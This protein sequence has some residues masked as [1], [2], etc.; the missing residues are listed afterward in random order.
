M[1]C[2]RHAFKDTGDKRV[3]NMKRF[4]WVVLAAAA[5]STASPVLAQSYVSDAEPFISAVKSRDGDKA[6]QLAND[7]PTVLNTRNAKGETALNI[8]I[9][10]SDE[11]WTQFLL[12]KGADPNFAASNGDTPLITAARVGFLPA[13][14]LLFQLGVKVDTANKMGETPLIVAVQQRE[15]EAVKLLL[16]HGADPDRKDSAAGYS[17]RDYAKRDNRTRD[18][19][20]AIEAAKKPASKPKSDDLNSFKL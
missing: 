6:T 17:A 12:G 10:R 8:V 2:Y 14:D 1:L 13:M 4:G 16:A 3:R 15:L 5:V 18:I 7:R 11:L 19:L 20:N 9:A